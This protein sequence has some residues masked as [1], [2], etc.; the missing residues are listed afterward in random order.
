MAKF[1]EY[2]PNKF[3]NIDTIIHIY[4]DHNIYYYRLLDGVTLEI[5]PEQHERI[6][7]LG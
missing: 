6:I 5:T 2:A 1:I 3:I 4:F 7:R